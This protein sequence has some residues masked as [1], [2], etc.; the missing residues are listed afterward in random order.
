MKI[1]LIHTHKTDSP[2]S[3]SGLAFRQGNLYAVGDDAPYLY[4]LDMDYATQRR[5]S[6]SDTAGFDKRIA[7]SE[8]MDFEALEFV[9]DDE[10]VVFGSGSKSPQRDVFAKVKINPEYA[11]EVF[12]ITDFYNHLRELPEFQNTELNIEAAAYHKGEMYLLN[13][14]KNLIISF[15]Y[16]DFIA[17]LK[18]G[19]TL[20]ELEITPCRLPEIQ[21]FEYGF[22]GATFLP[23]SGE[24]LFTASAEATDN[25]YDDGEILGSILGIMDKNGSVK[26]YVNIPQNDSEPL[27]IESVTVLNTDNGEYELLLVSDDDQGN[28]VFVKGIVTGI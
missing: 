4:V 24:I 28:S 10:L 13:R 17:Y 15:V 25:A 6:L 21:G 18:N 22:S 27:K 23:N 11:T 1:Q 20:P 16:Q 14:R 8:K 7:K 9:S 26:K 19:G 3:G 12:P 5:I 2:P